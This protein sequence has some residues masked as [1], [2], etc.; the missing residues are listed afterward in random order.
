MKGFK[1]LSEVI[2]GWATYKN[3]LNDGYSSSVLLTASDNSWKISR[4]LR[5][6]VSTILYF[7]QCQDKFR[8]KLWN[9]PDRK[10]APSSFQSFLV[11]CYDRVIVL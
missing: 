1:K 4:M 5:I 10:P 6:S 3:L 9:F 7:L 8:V 11:H 2:E